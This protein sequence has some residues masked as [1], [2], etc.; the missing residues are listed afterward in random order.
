[1][2]A[3]QVIH[4]EFNGQQVELLQREDGT[5]WLTQEQVGLAMGY[6]G[7]DAGRSR[8]V[9]QIYER[10]MAE[11]RPFRSSLKVRKDGVTKEVTVWRREGVYLLACFARTEQAAAFRLWVATTCEELERGDKVLVP[12]AYLEQLEAD[13]R[14]AL[15]AVSYVS[16]SLQL[17]ASLGASLMARKGH[18]QRSHPELFGDHSSGQTFFEFVEEPAALP[19][20]EPGDESG[21][22]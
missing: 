1:M 2:S 22:A 16:K 4:R 21:P 14:N 19:E 11:L 15:D 10:R 20:G 12:T 3:L 8:K 13:Q 9:S 6:S 7:D 5:L 18:L 17:A